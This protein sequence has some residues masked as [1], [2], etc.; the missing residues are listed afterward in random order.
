MTLC[1]LGTCYM[2]LLK[3]VG[4]LEPWSVNSTGVDFPDAFK[5]VATTIQQFFYYFTRTKF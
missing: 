1:G 4:S 5:S 2:C 3:Q